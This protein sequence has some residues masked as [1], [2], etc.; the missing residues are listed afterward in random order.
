MNRLKR[1]VLA[2]IL[3]MGTAALSHGQVFTVTLSGLV[4][5]QSG[6]SV[7]NA[8]LH[9]R[10]LE[11]NDTREI[12][13]GPDGRYSFTQIRP[14]SY[15]L[16]VEAKGFKRF[17]QPSITLNASQ[18]AEFNPTMEVGESTQRV[19]V[20]A[21][22]PV[23]DTQ[24]ADKSVTLEARQIIDLPTNF[25]NPLVLVWQTAGVVAVRTGLSQ[26]DQEQN[27]NR[28]A[29]NGGRDEGAALLIDGVPSTSGDWGGAIATPSIEATAEVQVVRNTFDVQYGRTDGG[30]VSVI[31]KGGADA[32]HGTA[33]NYLRNSRL[34][35]NTWDN[36]RAGVRKPVFQ[37]NQFGGALSGPIWKSKHLYFF[38]DYDGMRQGSPST[39]LVSV[40]TALERG[41]DFSQ[42]YN[43][44]GTL[45]TI[46]NPF[47]TRT[48]PSGSGFVRDAFPGNVIPM[49][50]W[51]PVGAKAAGLFP[52]PNLPGNALTHVLDYGAGGKTVGIND[53]M[54]IRVDWARS[55]HYSFFVRVTK[56]WEQNVAPVLLGNHV[57]NNFSDNNP[58]HQVVI[59]NTF[60]PTPTW[61]TN[62][63]IGTGRWREA[64]LSPS[65]G[66]DGTAIGL[67]ASTVAL[68]SAKTIPQFNIANYVTLGN[69]RYL[70]DPRTT[71]NLQINNS[72]SFRSHGLK[73][74][75][76][77][78]V[79]QINGTDIRSADFTFNR[80]LTSGPTASTDSTT[81]GNA[82]ASLLL[83]TGASGTSPNNARLA[84]EEKYYAFYVQDTW[85]I[86]HRLTLDYGV[87]YDLQLPATERYNRL[88][89]FATQ[90][91][92]PV[93]KQAGMD[94]TGGLVFL[95]DKSRGLWDTASRNFAPRVGLSFK[96]TDKFVIRTGYGLYYPPAWAGTAT[97]DGFSATTQWVST[98]GG[99]GLLP[100]SL[101][102]NPFPQGTVPAIGGSLGAAT[103]AGNS[104]NAY[105]RHHPSPYMQGYS[106][107]LQYQLG[108]SSMIEVG[109]SGSQ[110]RKLF[111]GYST[112]LNINQL[113]PK[114]LSLGSAL[115]NPVSNPF[116]GIVQ[117]GPLSG[118]TVSQYQLLLPFPQF[119]A[120]NLSALTP[121]ASSSYNALLLKFNRR[122]DHGLQVLVTYQWSKALDNAS[123]TQGW[124]ISD[125]PRNNYNYSIERSVSGH[126][127]PQDFTASVL[128]ELPVGKG[129]GYLANLP[130]AADYVIGG[131][132]I[133][134]TMRFG[135]GLPLQFTAPNSLSTYGYPVGRPNITSLGD[136][137]S[138]G[139]QGPD[140][141]FNT[142]AVSAAA[143][144][145][146]GSAP[147]WIA[148]LRTGPLD[149]ADI[150]LSK[151]FDIWERLKMTFRADAF[152]LSNTPQYGRANTSVGN[153]AFGQ[154]TGTTYVTPRNIQAA[155]RFDF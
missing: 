64:Q 136:L 84:T 79:M 117:N 137:V 131:W 21:A 151:R 116:Y 7:P 108:N 93:A 39:T 40:P 66:L 128:Y 122:F 80:G 82:V 153:G 120:V 53:K 152:N 154:V 28:F 35:S 102:S 155:L 118:Q 143:P 141:W 134:T 48:N 41:G 90:I 138:G 115:N 49:N 145:T 50:L 51:D 23:L 105:F 119:T 25:R 112:P 42:T 142:G 62:V 17:V 76:I 100:N 26:A 148:N 67:P 36:N 89:N 75:F 61:V 99:G 132:Q 33:Y 126:D 125:A 29:L 104:V 22:A 30:V 91:S 83:G 144:F 109:Y 113:D 54:D 27:Q 146:I 71:N 8:A 95:N 63:L 103:L 6:G 86:G 52:Q 81:T 14:G 58:R 106:L 147:R 45:S 87:R 69:A 15:E 13:T 139:N 46:Y 18:A 96:I 129:R 38:G 73:F 110:G 124:E 92:N 3:S 149:S 140:H 19:E 31:T 127:I 78:E 114:Y 150:S 57:D 20:S 72:K 111:Y 55:E 43:A 34:D 60:V 1:T 4:T 94:L 59:G 70:N 47:T 2:L 98:V 5:D 44:N 37:R 68:F 135:S 74:G 77:A 121:G 32:F 10:N 133:A 9:I 85:R 12:E 123:E 24:S 65:Q 88:N 107:D 97:S 11:T 101:V 130:K 16:T 56:G